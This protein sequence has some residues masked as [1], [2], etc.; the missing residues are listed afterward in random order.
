[1]LPKIKASRWFA[2]AEVMALARK[3]EETFVQKLVKEECGFCLGE[4]KGYNGIPEGDVCT[5][6]EHE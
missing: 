6:T 5:L 1:M 2:A 3:T 4:A